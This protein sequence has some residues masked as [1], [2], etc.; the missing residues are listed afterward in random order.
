MIPSLSSSMNS[1]LTDLSR[2]Q[3]TI[4]TATLQLS[5]GYRITQASDAPDQISPLLQLEANLSHNQAVLSQLTRVQTQI[6][7]ADQAVS[8]AIS[9]LDQARSIGA[10]GANGMTSAATRTSLATQMQSLQEQMV[11]LSNTNAGG[12]YVFGGDQPT[13]APYALNLNQTV[14]V[15]Q[16]GVDQLL[17]LP[18]AATR[19]AEV[20]DRA[21]IPVDQTAEDL[22][23]HRAQDGS[24][25]TDNVF[26]AL[27]AMRAVLTQ[28]DQPGILAA[29]KSLEGASSYLN[30]KETFYGNTENRI[31]AAIDRVNL[32]N[33]DL[34]QQISAI[35]DTD[36]VAAALQLTSAETES[37]A[38]L[39]AQAKIPR[40]TLFDY[41]G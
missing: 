3:S 6:S 14:N 18:V 4:N 38:A 7:S 34:R 24:L 15:P 32:Q 35:R 2:L 16:H 33:A 26:A 37:Q 30:S 40:T 1:F 21:L 9:L 36:V 11:T 27:N 13:V 31:S 5:S 22:F 17:V 25:A 20:S 8:S 23:D 29:Q 41:L 39:A 19:K 28:N 10:Q 12:Q